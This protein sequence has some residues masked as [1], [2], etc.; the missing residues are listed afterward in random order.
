MTFP[1]PLRLCGGNSLSDKGT[2]VSHFVCSGQNRLN[3]FFISGAAA[4]IAGEILLD[5]FLCWFWILVKQGLSSHNHSRSTIPALN[6]KMFNKRLL[7]RMQFTFLVT[8]DPLN[9]Q[10]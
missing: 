1:R 10:A 2:P 6:R 9:G 8:A 7:K 5:L 3:N 4:Q